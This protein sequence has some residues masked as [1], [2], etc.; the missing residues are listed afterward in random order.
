QKDAHRRKGKAEQHLVGVPQRTRQIGT[1]QPAGKLQCP[2]AD[3]QRG[4]HAGQQIERA[5]AELPQRKAAHGKRRARRL[6]DSNETSHDRPCAVRTA[7]S[8][9]STLASAWRLR[10]RSASV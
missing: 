3:R 5:K 6:F 9:N 4:E 8:M 7:W 2:Q 1:A 10:T